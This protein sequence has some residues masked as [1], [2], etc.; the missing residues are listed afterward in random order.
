MRHSDKFIFSHHPYAIDYSSLRWEGEWGHI[1]AI[2]FRRRHGVSS[3]HIGGLRNLTHLR[4]TD[5]VSFLEEFVGREH[6]GYCTARWDG[7]TYLGPKK[8]E[9]MAANLE[10]LRPL[11]DGFLSRKYEQAPWIPEN[12]TGWWT[13]RQSRRKS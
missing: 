4:T 10:I 13:F 12:Y 7:E 9:V 3:V 6:S 2:W 1:G 11:L 8:P 5:P